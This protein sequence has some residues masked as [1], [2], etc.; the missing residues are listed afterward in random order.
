MAYTP[1]TKDDQPTMQAFNDAFEGAVKD[2]LARGVKIETGRY[3]GTGAYGAANP[4]S[5]TFGF[6]PKILIVTSRKT[7]YIYNDT[8][9]PI[10]VEFL[11]T[12]YESWSVGAY[13]ASGSVYMKKSSDGK[14]VH[15]Y[16]TAKGYA[17]SIAG[18]QNNV[19]GA[20]YYYIAIG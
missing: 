1:F 11:T 5:L 8:I 16:A 13:N 18:L 17:D 9:E 3:V 14:T 10:L 15:W 4:N 20:T 6:A 2:S 19:S 7:L 12:G